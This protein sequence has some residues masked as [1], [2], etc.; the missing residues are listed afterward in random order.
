MDLAGSDHG[1]ANGINSQDIM[2]NSK[3]TEQ[4]EKCQNKS[5]TFL[6][7][8]KIDD[9]ML[10]QGEGETRFRH[11]LSRIVPTDVKEQNAYLIDQLLRY[12]QMP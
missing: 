11:S 7:K 8:C 10:S 2:M 9:Y 5:M 6:F 1:G 4:L 12:G 3:I